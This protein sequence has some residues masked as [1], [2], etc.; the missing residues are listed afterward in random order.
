LNG[1]V[2][3]PN[4]RVHVKKLKSLITVMSY[5][6]PFY[7]SNCLKYVGPIITPKRRLE[8]VKVIEFPQSDRPHVSNERT[9]MKLA[10][11]SVEF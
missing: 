4:Q 2:F 10:Y 9:A 7:C 1:I 11:I 6:Q 5:N 3:T 8:C